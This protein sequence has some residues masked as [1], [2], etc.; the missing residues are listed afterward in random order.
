MKKTLLTVALMGAGLALLA[1]CKTH[2]TGAYL[3][4]NSSV[5]NLE[6][7]TKF[8]LLDKGA[9]YSVTCVDLQEARLPDGRLQVLANLRNRDNRRIQVQA[10]CVFKDAQGFVV[11]DTPFQNVFL[12]ENAQEGVKFVS[13]NDKALRY[14][15]RVRQAR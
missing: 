13:L 10:N 9:Q 15:V 6:D 1:G 14:T 5:N 8:V 3:P 12:D 11:E 7:S 4:L 2:D